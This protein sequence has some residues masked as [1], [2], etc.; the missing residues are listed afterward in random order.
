MPR[1]LEIGDTK[2]EWQSIIRFWMSGKDISIEQA[3]E[4]ATTSVPTVKR[5]LAL[6]GRSTRYG[7]KRWKAG[8]LNYFMKR[9]G[10]PKEMRDRV[11]DL[12][13][14]EEGYKL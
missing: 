1:P 4:L 11:N 2:N 13:A 7:R 10:V 3:A 6:P 12:A 5:L 9:I 8:F 14:K